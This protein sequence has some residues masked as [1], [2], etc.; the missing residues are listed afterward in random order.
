LSEKYHLF[1]PSRRELDLLNENR[2]SRYLQT[3][4]IDVIIHCAAVGGYGQHLYVKGMFYDNLRM[5]FNLARCKRYYKYF[6]NIGSGA[7]YD[8]RSPIVKAKETDFG[9]HIPNDEYGLYKYICSD[10]I[11]KMENMVDLR[12]FGLFGKGEDY[13]T[14]FISN[15]ICR[16][17][18]KLPLTIR[19]NV[20]FDYLYIRDFI[21]IIEYF[22]NNKSK[23]TSYNIGNAQIFSL[24]S[25]AKIINSVGKRPEKIRVNKSGLGNEYSGN[26]HRLYAEVVNI[27]LTPIQESIEDLYSWYLSN[28]HM[29]NPKLL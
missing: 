28:V 21:K 26:S 9:K 19:Q 10:Y 27:S 8:K 14:R 4:P 18:F 1:T 13:T 16:H 6:I 24:L 23:Y 17:I 5:F 22:I 7:V 11:S 15:T 12:V 3:H 20:N 25:L 2:V 29:I